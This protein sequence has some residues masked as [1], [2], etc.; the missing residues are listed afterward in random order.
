VNSAVEVIFD[1]MGDAYYPREAEI[2]HSSASDG[3]SIRVESHSNAS[4]GRTFHF[5]SDSAD[6]LHGVGDTAVYNFN[7]DWT[8]DNMVF[9]VRYSDDVAGNVIEVYLDDVLKGTFTTD[10][11]GTWE[12][13]S[14]D[15]EVIKLGTINAGSHTI[16]LCVTTGGS[17]GVN[18]DAFVLAKSGRD[19]VMCTGD[20]DRDGDVDGADLAHAA[21]DFGGVDAGELAQSFGLRGCYIPVAF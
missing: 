17:W 7:V 2:F 1:R 21:A 4:A 13:F 16:K 5:G 3:S 15:A 10:D 14:W 11:T 18:L 6:P 12:D 9:K 8:S 19:G 20:F